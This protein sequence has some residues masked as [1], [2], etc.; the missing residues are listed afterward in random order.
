M[1]AA[2][3]VPTDTDS[4]SAMPTSETTRARAER[5]LRRLAD[6]GETV[7]DGLDDPL[8]APDY[9][10]DAMARAGAALVELAKLDW[11]HAA[12]A[13]PPT[14]VLLD[15]EGDLWVRIDADDDKFECSS[16]HEEDMALEHIRERF[17]IAREFVAAPPGR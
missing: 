13:A 6:L 4:L 14:E 5:V 12:T 3:H 15:G 8:D 11:Q 10:L 9:L 7:L 17:G 2:D 16:S 1:T